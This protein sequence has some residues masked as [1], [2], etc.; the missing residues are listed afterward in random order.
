MISN[1]LLDIM[2]P[3]NALASPSMRNFCLSCLCLAPRGLQSQ[4]LPE[5]RLRNIPSLYMGAITITIAMPGL[6]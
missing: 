1:A 3:R 6:H 2:V 4:K 5:Q